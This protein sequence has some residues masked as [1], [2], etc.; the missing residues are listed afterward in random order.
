MPYM[1]FC[2]ISQ[3]L[4]VGSWDIVLTG[5]GIFITVLT[6]VVLIMKSYSKDLNNKV[7]KAEFNK[8]VDTNCKEHEA[9][10][11]HV[12][13]KVGLKEFE[14]ES[15]NTRM[16]FTGIQVELHESKKQL[17]EQV[18]TNTELLLLTKEVITDMKWI[19]DKIAK[20]D[21]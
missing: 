8:H 5:I 1:L 20:L 2:T 4:T 16:F 15:S 10:D 13:S 21:N 11:L 3:I 17:A 19:K 6:S 18:K 7:D 14:Q 9:I 12:S